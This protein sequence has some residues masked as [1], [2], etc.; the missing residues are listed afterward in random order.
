MPILQV[1]RLFI[2]A[3]AG[4]IALELPGCTMQNS[5]SSNCHTEMV[6]MRDG[7]KL[8]TDIYQPATAG[9]HPVV[10]LRSPYGATLGAGCGAKFETQQLDPYVK[11]G[12]V[13][14][15]QDV[16]G[17]NRSEGTFAPFAQEQNDGYDAVE[18]AGRQPW[19]DGSVSLVGGSYLGATQWQ[20]ALAEPPHLTA[21]TP[22]I[23]AADYHDDWAYRNGVF[24]PLF[25]MGWVTGAFVPDGM[26]RTLRYQGAT[27][28]DID[29]QV[30]AWQQQR[31]ANLTS[32]WLPH[33]P[34]AGSWNPP[35][36]QYAPFYADFLRHP[37]YDP[38]WARVDVNRQYG[39]VDA[40]TLITGAWYDLFAVGT[41][42]AY[43]GM[44]DKAG[45]LA[46]RQRT[47]LAMSWGGH[48][49]LSPAA[50]GQID[51]GPD[52]SDTT[53]AKRFVD[54]YAKGVDNGIER[55][56][57]VQL[58]VLV[59]PDRG[60]KGSSFLY[61][62][63]DFPAPGTR[64][65]RFYL[66]SQGRAN[67]RRGDGVL[68]A[69]QSSGEPDHFAYDPMDP[70]PT[71][72]G[73]DGGVSPLPGGAFDQSSIESRNDV[74]VYQSAP[75][76]DDMP[77]VGPVTVSFWASSS[78][79]D[80]DFTAK[81]VDAHPDGFAHNVVDRIVRASLR[82]GSALPPEP[83]LRNRSYPYTINL[84]STATIFRKGHRVLLE[85]SSSNFP[86]YAR[87]LNTGEPS[88]TGS[89]TAVA[90]QTI[91]HDDG[92][93]SWLELPVLPGVEPSR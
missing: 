73:N 45:T 42:D 46:A 40:P 64:W 34:L 25:T 23:T 90:H 58:V 85:I 24:D 93:P 75:L 1:R 55:E 8:A 83:T 26:T 11:D 91:W 49:A 13:A 50:P 54:H 6:A 66:A 21:I 32:R 30:A 3:V 84:G 82:R 56:P 53:L 20:A 19:S 27:K 44:R 86:H 48:S 12:Y 22:T 62:T 9:R 63:T 41:I 17:T 4:L 14:I 39:K 65:A 92:H 74:L 79:P 57:R 52:P 7:S 61:K 15:A 29:A 77:V 10:M 18:W 89:E 60:L 80:T 31:E 87:N 51:W 72:G 43:W 28:A 70:A 81:L 35:V 68:V 16:R 47:M 38:Y 59:P 36:A 37:Y 5:G 71:R 76:A 78:A 33:L 67:T 88:E 69:E 2:F